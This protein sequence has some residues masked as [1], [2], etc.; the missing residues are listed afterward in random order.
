VVKEAKQAGYV[1][2]IAVLIVGAAA[3]AIGVALLSTGADSQRVALNRLQSR[4][5]RSLAVACGEEALQQIHDN[6]SYT[7]S[8]GTM[9]MGQG[10]CTYKVSINTPTSS[11]ISA[12][13][14]VG[15]VTRKVLA[16]VTIGSTLS[17]TSWK[18]VSDTTATIT[19]VQSIG[20]T[21]DASATTIVR[22]F[23]SNATAGN[24]IVAAV[25]WDST[26]TQAVTCSDTQGNTFTTVNVWND[27][28]NQ[29]ALA[30]CYAVRITGGADTITATF[31]ASS[32]FRRIIISEYSGVLGVSPA[33]VFAGVGGQVA[34]TGA[35]AV[36]SGPATTT[37]NGAL[38]Y[39]AVMDTTSTTT[40]AAGSG[41][42]QRTS[43]NSKD[44]AVQD[45]QQA[46]AGSI[47]S[48]QTFGATHRYNAA[49]VAFKPASQ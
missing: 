38:I 47:A 31:G 39:G 33:D 41:F 19:H 1:A 11:N 12:T 4:Q 30:L 20:T 7:T 14:T 28:T 34:T 37:Q 9:S 40:I 23:S 15:T 24:L 16:T 43:L 25:S 48:T 45:L 36:T 29:Q 21:A 8:N 6:A 49:F 32:A 13:G 17:A 22:A 27:A 3:T 10:S 5:A 35:N 44:L 26:A 2:L 18:D 42:T 46:T